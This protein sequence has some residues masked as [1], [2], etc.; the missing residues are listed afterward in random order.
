MLDLNYD[1]TTV[2]TWYM[3]YFVLPGMKI[4]TLEISTENFKLLFSST[5]LSSV[6]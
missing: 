5:N 2:L 3:F 6:S 4:Q 1:V